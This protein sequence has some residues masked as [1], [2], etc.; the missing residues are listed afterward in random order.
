LGVNGAGIADRFGAPWHGVG[1]LDLD[2]TA[3]GHLLTGELY[4]GPPRSPGGAD[5]EWG[6]YLQD[7]IPI[8][9][10]L[11]GVLRYEHYDGPGRPLDAGVFG[12]AC[13]PWKHLILKVDYQVGN[14][15]V[16]DFERGFFAS[17]TLFF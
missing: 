2:V 17:V 9:D 4:Y 11:Y 16:E 12:V 7:A 5:A 3:F 1:G 14:R 8:V 10:R 15:D 6:F 13:W